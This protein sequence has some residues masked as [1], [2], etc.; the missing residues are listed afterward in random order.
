MSPSTTSSNNNAQG[1]RVPDRRHSISRAANEAD[2]MQEIGPSI[3][4]YHIKRE[5][6]LIPP[7]EEFRWGYE[8]PRRRYETRSRYNN[9]YVARSFFK[10]DWD[11]G[12]TDRGVD[13]RYRNY[14]FEGPRGETREYVAGAEAPTVPQTRHLWR[15]VD[16]GDDEGV[17]PLYD[18]PPIDWDENTSWSDDEH[19]DPLGQ[20]DV[21]NEIGPVTELQ[22]HAQVDASGEKLENLQNIAAQAFL[23]LGDNNLG[24][25]HGTR[26]EAEIDPSG[27]MRDV[28]RE[29]VDE[30]PQTPDEYHVTSNVPA[31]LESSPKS[32]EVEDR[33]RNY[34]RLREDTEGKPM[35]SN[36]RGIKWWRGNP[37]DGLD[38]DDSCDE[39][40]QPQPMRP[41]IQFEQP[42]RT[43]RTV[44]QGS[45]T[46]DN[47]KADNSSNDVD[48][49]ETDASSVDSGL[50]NFQSKQALGP[51]RTRARPPFYGISVQTNNVTKKPE[52]VP[53]SNEVDDIVLLHVRKLEPRA[54]EYPPGLPPRIEPKSGPWTEEDEDLR[55]WF[56]NYGMQKK[57][58]EIFW[59]LHRSKDDCQTRYR[60]IVMKRNRWA[61]RHLEA[62]LPGWVDHELQVTPEEIA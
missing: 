16:Q 42:V 57:W 50:S 10:I 46:L 39:E 47:S 38:E 24:P 33:K 27:K 61:C 32:T 56:Q 15:L 23:M 48:S 36:S 20:T 55:S 12:F 31:S 19:I 29:V 45:G 21:D 3:F 58:S 41:R 14:R 22:Q 37:L 13:S 18:G 6:V 7:N 34:H 44:G 35:S 26:Q 17:D 1:N 59:C 2:V 54:Y 40:W 30:S 11:K 25:L 60:K 49:S 4:E 53:D 8:D 28:S 52:W 51:I 62:G 5:T 9:T 43:G